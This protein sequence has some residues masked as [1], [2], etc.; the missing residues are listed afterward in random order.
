MS[1][2][3][4]RRNGILGLLVLYEPI[5]SLVRHGDLAGVGINGAKREI[6]NG[7]AV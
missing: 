3:Q 5:K 1:Y 7:E 6:L 4:H 2:M